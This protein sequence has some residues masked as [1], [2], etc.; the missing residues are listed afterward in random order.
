MPEPTGSSQSLVEVGLDPCGVFG[1][2]VSQELA[3]DFQL[4]GVGLRP[5]SLLEN[6]DVPALDVVLHR[7]IL[8]RGFGFERVFVGLGHEGHSLSAEVSHLILVQ[9]L[10]TRLFNS[11]HIEIGTEIVGDDRRE[12]AG[13]D[14]P[15]NDRRGFGFP[16]PL[17]TLATFLLCKTLSAPPHPSRRAGIFEPTD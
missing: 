13:Q 3:Q 9:N 7:E 2:F 1:Y 12:G 11:I 17:P 15:L 8:A 14:N 6:C 4:G 16:L 10:Q 5:D